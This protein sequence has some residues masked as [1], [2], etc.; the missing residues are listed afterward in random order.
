[1]YMLDDTL[2]M[3]IVLCLIILACICVFIYI[4]YIKK[5]VT[6]KSYVLSHT[7]VIPV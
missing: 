4:Q 6:V 3:L 5:Q 2:Y 1:M 7:K